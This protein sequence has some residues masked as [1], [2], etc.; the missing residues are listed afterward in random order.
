MHNK[1]VNF[2]K[3]NRGKIEVAL[4]VG[5]TTALVLTGKEN[6]AQKRLLR[7]TY[8]SARDLDLADK[9]TAHAVENY[10]RCIS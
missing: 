5:L 6:L 10:T 8:Q 7:I 3:S 2:V 9:I 4:F 1:I